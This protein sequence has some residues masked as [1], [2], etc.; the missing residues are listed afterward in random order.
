MDIIPN[1]GTESTCEEKMFPALQNML[2]AKHT[3][4]ITFNL[5]MPS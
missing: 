3:I 2:M 5:P 4:I 1:P